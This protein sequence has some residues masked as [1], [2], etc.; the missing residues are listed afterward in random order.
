[1]GEGLQGQWV[2]YNQIYL[3]IY[4]HPFGNSPTIQTGRQLFAFDGSNNMDSCKNVTFGNF[5]DIAVHLGCH[6][7]P[8]PILGAWIGIFKR[9]MPNIQTFKLLKLPHGSQPKLHMHNNYQVLFVGG[10]NASHAEWQMA[11]IFKMKM[12]LLFILLNFQKM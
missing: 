2:K 10:S 5:A 1:M 8:N 12:E 4:L 9:N 11:T 7:Q 3:F 6:I